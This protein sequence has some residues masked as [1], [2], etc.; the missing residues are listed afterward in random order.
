SMDLLYL[1][2]EEQSATGNRLD[3]GTFVASAQGK[4]LGATVGH[5][6][7]AGQSLLFDGYQKRGIAITGNWQA[8]RS[9]LTV[10]GVSAQELT[11]ADDALGIS[12]GDNR[13]HGGL[14]ETRL[15]QS[16]SYEAHL[17]GAY[18]RGT[19]SQAGYGSWSQEVPVT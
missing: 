16:E 2:R 7:V 4:Y 1:H 5:Q 12:D 10:F 13:Y 9:K 17:S 11:G 19:R 15:W 18:F 8:A 14:V 3:V 6:A